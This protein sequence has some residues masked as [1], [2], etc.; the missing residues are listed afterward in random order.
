MAIDPSGRGT[1]ETAYAIVRYLNGY[2]FLV[3]MGG[4][5]EGYS[6]SVLTQ[7]GNKTKVYGVNEVIIEGNF[8]D[9][10]FTQLFKPI[11]LKIHPC[12][13]QEV[14]NTQQKEARIIDTLE[15]VMM[16]HKLIIAE[17]VIKE[18]YSVYENKG[19]KYS[20]IY[21]LTRISRDR[22]SLAHD[23]RLDALT[24]AI[25]YWLS[26]MDRDEEQGMEEQLEEFLE[27]AMDE[28]RGL[29][30]MMYGAENDT[31]NSNIMN[32]KW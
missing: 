3:D 8:G 21:Q 16:R 22:G 31:G 32:K 28:D 2:L 27:A 12:A 5:S 20:L 1:D 14:K 7:L 11:L 24:M 26:V 17:Q 18:D 4:Y 23:D 30:S 9:G 6:D 13:I 15:P 29:L 10:M 19:Q 25:A